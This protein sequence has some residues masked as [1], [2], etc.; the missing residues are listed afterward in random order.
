MDRKRALKL[1]RIIALFFTISALLLIPSCRDSELPEDYAADVPTKEQ[2]SEIRSF[3][4]YT[5]EPAAPIPSAE[6]ETIAPA[7]TSEQTADTAESIDVPVDEETADI[8]F[9]YGKV[10]LIDRW[11]HDI[12][13]LDTADYINTFHDHGSTI[14]N[15]TWYN[16]SIMRYS[17]GTF[18]LE[19]E[20]DRFVES[21]NAVNNTDI[22]DILNNSDYI[23]LSEKDEYNGLSVEKAY[24]TLEHLYR[25]NRASVM[26][27][28]NVVL[29]GIAE[30]IKE[31]GPM[32]IEKRGDVFFYPYPESIA[33]YPLLLPPYDYIYSR[34]IDDENN[35]YMYAD[36]LRLYLGNAF[37]GKVYTR[38]MEVHMEE[39]GWFTNEELAAFVTENINEGTYYEIEIEVSNIILNQY[40][41][42]ISGHPFSAAN[43]T[44]LIDADKLL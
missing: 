9:T 23:V 15:A 29:K 32:E 16:T 11:W 26:L 8:Y 10:P 34:I 3:E 7:D 12:I 33:D 22:N 30:I 35:F 18:I 40:E 27:N 37:T 4:E 14:K 5:S 44:R 39:P 17:L 31:P 28:S 13:D 24:F 38:L 20:Y 41:E 19:N 36:T 43:V 1:T 6:T 42:V 25:F 2:S 21:L